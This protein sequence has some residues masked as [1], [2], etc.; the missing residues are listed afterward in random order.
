M[1]KVITRLFF[2]AIFIQ[3]LSCQTYF[4]YVAN[5]NFQNNTCTYSQLSYQYGC[6]L[7]LDSNSWTSDNLDGNINSIQLEYG[8]NYFYTSSS[9]IVACLDWYHVDHYHYNP[10]ITVMHPITA[11][12][13]RL[14][15]TAYTRRTGSVTNYYFYVYVFD[16]NG[17][18]Y[19]NGKMYQFS[20]LG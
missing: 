8:Y 17:N 18:N 9:S 4:N 14:T 6:S 15:F 19:L 7:S 3:I 11:G 12:T 1:S 16:S 5:G 2:F 20:Y 13:Y 10:I